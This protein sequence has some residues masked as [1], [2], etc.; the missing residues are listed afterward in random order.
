MFWNAQVHVSGKSRYVL[1]VT[2]VRFG[3]SLCELMCKRKE[4]EKGRRDKHT[5]WRE[6][7]REREREK[8]ERERERERDTHTHTRARARARACK[9]KERE[10]EREI[11]LQADWPAYIEGS[12]PSCQ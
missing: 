12:Y 1:S 3:V 11:D 5:R 2:L 7:E 10:R 4:V 8:R 9:K 6:R